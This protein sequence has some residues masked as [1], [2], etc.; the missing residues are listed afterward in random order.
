MKKFVTVFL[1]IFSLNA[2]TVDFGSW[3]CGKVVQWER[4]NNKVQMGAISLW[5]AGF[6]EGRNWSEGASKFDG[7]DKETL[8]FFF[9]MN[10]EK[11]PRQTHIL[12]QLKFMTGDI[13]IKTVTNNSNRSRWNNLECRIK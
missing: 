13:E 5:F 1:L 11:T 9:Q 7:Y 6:I 12:R 4:D 8:S 10:V 3:S 2:F